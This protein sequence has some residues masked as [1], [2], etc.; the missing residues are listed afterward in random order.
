MVVQLAVQFFFGE[1]VMARNTAG[2]LEESKMKRIKAIV[3][4]K[5]G[6]KCGEVDREAFWAKCKTA[7]GQKCK[8]LHAAQRAKGSMRTEMLCS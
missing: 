3:I 5:F 6:E 7:I 8:M 2:T 4:F 1:A